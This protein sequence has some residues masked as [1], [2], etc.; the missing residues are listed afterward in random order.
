LL[1]QQE[2]TSAWKESGRVEHI[3]QAG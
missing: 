1:Q 2:Q 3:P